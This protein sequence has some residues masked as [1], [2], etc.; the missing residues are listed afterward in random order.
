MHQIGYTLPMANP[1]SPRRDGWTF[2]RRRAFCAL[3]ARCG[4]VTLSAAQVGMSASTAYRARKR[5]G[6]E[7]F[8]RDWDIALEMFR[9]AFG[10]HALV[11]ALTRRTVSVI[12]NGVHVADKH[13]YNDRH[14]LAVLKQLFPEGLMGTTTF[15]PT[16]VTLSP[17]RRPR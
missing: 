4:D 14:M 10:H 5:E 12:R 13:K 15:A 6:M 17:P 3:L 8:A 11:G 1:R 7:G 9:D 2:A 16:G